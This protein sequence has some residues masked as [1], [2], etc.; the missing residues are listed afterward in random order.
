MYGHKICSFVNIYFEDKWNIIVAIGICFQMLN[1]FYSGNPEQ[2]KRF[3]KNTK[4][5]IVNRHQIFFQH[6][7]WWIG[8]TKA[9]VLN[10]FLQLSPKIIVFL[11]HV[12]TYVTHLN[13]YLPVNTDSL[14]KSSIIVINIQQ[15]K[16]YAL[17][18]SNAIQSW[19]Y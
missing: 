10:L 5:I 17:L 8:L 3:V 2:N 6:S 11:V 7:V 14:S 4:I 15:Y 16:L 9:L 13:I 12:F 1:S 18:N 19:K